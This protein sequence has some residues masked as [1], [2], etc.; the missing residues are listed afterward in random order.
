M[1]ADVG[2]DACSQE[3]TARVNLESLSYACDKLQTRDDPHPAGQN[4]Q[5]GFLSE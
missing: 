3:A 1:I 4:L 2:E 5:S